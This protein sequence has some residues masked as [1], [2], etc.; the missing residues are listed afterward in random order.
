MGTTLS[1][2]QAAAMP[3]AYLTALQGLRDHGKLLEGGKVLVIGASGG[4]GLPALELAKAMGASEIVGVCSG[5]NRELVME[6]GAT[7]VIDY[8]T[9]KLNGGPF[10]VI[11]DAATASG[12]GEDYKASSKALLVPKTGTYVPLNQVMLDHPNV[13]PTIATTF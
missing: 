6:H 7:R 11:Y 8:N 12:A 2:T 4:T 5:R 3:T 13:V 10:D 9:D 1:F